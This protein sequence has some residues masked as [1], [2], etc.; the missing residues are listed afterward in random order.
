MN[1][2]TPEQLELDLH[3]PQK[4]DYTSFIVTGESNVLLS[5]KPTRNVTFHNETAEIGR[6]DWSDGIMTFKGNA[7]ES[8]EKFFDCIIKR[9]AEWTRI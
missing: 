8:A 6:L 9:Y 5:S 4:F 2:P 7:D 1:T 3:K